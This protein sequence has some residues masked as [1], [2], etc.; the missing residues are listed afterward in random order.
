MEDLNIDLLRAFLFVHQSG[1]F[2]KAAELLGRSQPAVSLQIKRLE[3]KMGGSVFRRARS[4]TP[5]LT[6]LGFMLLEYTNQ[7][8]AL[9]D[10]LIGRLAKPIIRNRIRLGILEELGH[11]RLPMVLRSLAGV[12]QGANPHVQVSLSNQL[13]SDMLQGQLDLAVVS[14]E[15]KFIN[16]L[17]LWKEPLVWVGSGAFPITLKPPLQLVL[18]PEPCFYRRAAVDALESAR[19][20]WTQAGVSSTMA[21]VRATVVAGLGISVMGESEISE[22]LRII[23]ND[24][25]LPR[26]P[27]EEIMLYYRSSDMN[28]VAHF[29]AA[30]ISRAT[31]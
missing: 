11:S 31:I 9:H 1:S 5:S 8:I 14:G 10:E 28:D 3:K 2:S 23:G 16:S 15:A 20:R 19:V 7:I 13:V 22:G 18:L 12:F 24:F 21:G 17:P 26:L 27:T 30:Q 6:P 29:L 25:A 4:G